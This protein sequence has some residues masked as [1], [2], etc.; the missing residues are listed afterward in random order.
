MMQTQTT[1]REALNHKVV[2]KAILK[3]QE[4]L[5]EGV[6]R[7]ISEDKQEPEWMLQKRFQALKFF[8]EKPMPNWGPSL[9]KLDLNKIIYYIK[10]S[11]RGNATDW[12]D[13]PPE[14]RETFDKLGI[15]EVERK[16]LGGSG[17]Q[18][19]SITAYHKLKEEWSKK[20]VIFEDMDV[21]L[22]KHPDLVK[23]YFMT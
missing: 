21:A 20:G 19:E 14:I 2:T 8:Y 17:A 6:V 18:F 5:S 22:Q 7:L 4:G 10:S 16:Y 11:E 12:N 23:Q 3:T 1:M 9:E 13:V 15:P